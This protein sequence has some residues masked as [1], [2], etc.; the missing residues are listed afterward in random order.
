MQTGKQKK[1]QKDVRGGKQEELSLKGRAGHPNWTEINEE[2]S[3]V[4]LEMF[5]RQNMK[6]NSEKI[7]FREIV[8]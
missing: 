2:C 3:E 6:L 1:V 5:P 7:C 8:S 4:E